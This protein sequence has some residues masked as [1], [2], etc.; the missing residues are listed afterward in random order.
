MSTISTRREQLVSSISKK[1][2]REA[3]VASRIRIRLPAQI[4]E[5]RLTRGLSQAE[6]GK[7]A[8]MKQSAI[9]RCEGMGYDQFTIST[10]KALAGAF[11]VGL[12]V[13]FVSFS[14]IVENASSPEIYPLDV[15]SFELDFQLWL[16][17]M[18]VVFTTDAPALSWAV[19][20]GETDF[21][22]GAVSVVF[23]CIQTMSGGV[24]A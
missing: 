14:E 15:P 23:P 21:Q 20:T 17:P 6:L 9:S 4:R 13:E 12:K 1:T 18:S 5:L 19:G 24:N 10:L 16:K 2:A 7:L 3:F 22:G 8:G 11:D